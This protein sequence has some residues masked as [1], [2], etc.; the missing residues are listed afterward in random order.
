MPAPSPSLLWG[1]PAI[2]RVESCARYG[3]RPSSERKVNSPMRLHLLAFL[4]GKSISA[5]CGNFYYAAQGR[6]RDAERCQR[7]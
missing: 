4:D 7:W 5:F 2:R 1:D 3:L 6:N